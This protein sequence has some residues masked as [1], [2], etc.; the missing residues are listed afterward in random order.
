MSFVVVTGATILCTMGAGAGVLNATAQ[1]GCIAG[2]K[3]IA[4]IQDVTPISNV[5]SC[6][7][8]TSLQ[9]PAVQ[10]ATA[11]ALGVLTPQPCIPSTIGTWSPAGAVRFGGK[12]CITQQSKLNCAYGGVI[13]IVSPG[14]NTILVK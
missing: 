5:G 6:G 7:M 12:P 3:P 9:N 2:G 11:A 10:S 14:Q 4:T 8:C 1:Q 13:N